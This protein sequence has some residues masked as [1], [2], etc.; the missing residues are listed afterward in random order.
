MERKN[1][2]SDEMKRNETIS[3][4]ASKCTRSTEICSFPFPFLYTQMTLS[5]SSLSR[6]LDSLKSHERKNQTSGPVVFVLLLLLHASL[7][8]CV[9]IFFFILIFILHCTLS[10]YSQLLNLRS[11][12]NVVSLD[13]LTHTYTHT[14]AQSIVK[15]ACN[16]DWLHSITKKNLFKHF[17][18]FSSWK[19]RLWRQ[20]LREK[21]AQTTLIQLLCVWKYSRFNLNW[22]IQYR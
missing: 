1:V 8:V 21:S 10:F 22:Q 15:F 9:M 7:F 4:Y 3:S 6:A 11:Q 16:T 20:N 18:Q 17:E 5:T 2:P 13:H 19:F 14:C 12:Q